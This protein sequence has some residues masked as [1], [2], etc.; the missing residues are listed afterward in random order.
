MNTLLIGLLAAT[1][2]NA[3]VQPEIP[4]AP[5]EKAEKKPTAIGHMVYFTLKDRTDENAEKLVA[6]CDKY[7]SD[8]PGVRFYAA[9]VLAKEF[10]AEPN[11]Q[12]FDVALHV[13]F[14]NAAAY[15]KYTPHPMHLKFIEESK[16]LWSKV[17]VFDSKLTLKAKPKAKQ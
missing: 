6:N 10:A 17:R 15:K 16:D 2:W 12:E 13:I 3:Q 14:N 7:L 11:D 4:T 5:T 1:Q 9:G 8:M